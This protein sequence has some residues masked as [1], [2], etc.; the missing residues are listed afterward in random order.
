MQTKT[1]P[2]EA[3]GKN[4]RFKIVTPR[5]LEGP[6]NSRPVIFLILKKT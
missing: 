1:F 3:R 4:T 6:R 5:E 2:S